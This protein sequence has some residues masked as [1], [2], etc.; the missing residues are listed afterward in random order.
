MKSFTKNTKSLKIVFSWIPLRYLLKR[1]QVTD[2]VVF[3][4][5]IFYEVLVVCKLMNFIQSFCALV[6][7]ENL[8]FRGEWSRRKKLKT[9][10][11]KRAKASLSLSFDT[12]FLVKST[13]STQLRPLNT[14]TLHQKRRRKNFS[15][16]FLNHLEEYMMWLIC[17]L[18]VI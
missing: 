4:E 11:K 12:H 5:K 6:F 7:A 9:L 15:S 16:I 14:S 2:G 3:T 18:S 10:K 13:T 17:F 1:T 8:F